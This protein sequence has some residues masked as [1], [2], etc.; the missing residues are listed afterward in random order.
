MSTD[1]PD[2]LNGPFLK[3]D[4]IFY[5][6]YQ[7]NVVNQCKNKNSLVVLPTGLGKTIVGILQIA[8]CL[9]KHKSLA[10]V[11][12]LAPTKPL[13]SQH[14]ASIEKFVDIDKEKIV[15]LTGKTP[16]EKRI[17]LFNKSKIIVSTPQV[18]K[19][20]L[21]RGRYD[22]KSVGLIIFDEA[23]R[24]KGNYAYNFISTE[25]INNCRDPLILGLTAS[26]GN[27]FERIQ[28]LCDNLYI[29]NI[30]FKT[31]DD[32]DVKDYIFDV[33]T[34]IERVDLPLNLLEISEIWNHLFRNFLKFFTEKNL[35]N[36]YKRYYSK[37]D[38]LKISHDLTFSLKNESCQELDE[39]LYFQSPKIIDIVKEKK[40]NI[41]SIFS[42]CSSCISILH[43]KDLFETQ[44]ISLFKSFI[45]KLKYKAEQ[46]ILSAKRII[47]SEHFKFINSTIEKL[48]QSNLSHPKINKLI[49]IIREE[50]EEFQNKK[51]IIFTQ[52]RQMAE[53]LKNKLN[54][55][56]FSE[57]TVEKFIGQTTKR[58]DCGF[59]QNKQIEI[60]QE[61]REDKI[62]ILIATSVAE[63]G[64]D[65]PNVDAVIFYEPVP[66]EIRLIQRRGRTGRFASGRCYILLTESTVDIPFHIVANKK[67]HNMNS[68]LNEPEQLELNKGI[69]RKKINFS[70]NNKDYSEWAFIKNFKER[71]EREKEL[72]ADRSVEDIITEIDNF[73]KS[74]DYKNL[75]NYGVSFYSDLIRIDK[76]K[77]RKNISKLKGKK[78]SKSSER[79]IYLNKNVKTLINIAKISR[80]GKVGFSEF[81]DLA[82]EEDICDRKF[83]AHFN[84][85]C[86]L[87][88]LKKS[89][90]YVQ[91]IKDFN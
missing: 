28:L 49:S 87:G 64:L 26:P 18:I 16:P 66:S 80:N 29:E 47:N 69:E 40:L 62:N 44:D 68:I 7:K 52:Y 9:K 57:I 12:I 41:Q 86:Y 50:L 83:F 5:R 79:K 60:L 23:H 82:R 1:I 63:E 71:R 53:L 10:K 54:Q 35:I 17:I 72:L 74:S 14:R 38:F 31:I 22:L 30:V 67:E 51:I 46:D 59:P 43:A 76:E 8:N 32:H 36:P 75:K 77:L 78:I 34:F 91:F 85:A 21:M 42:Y 84:Q 15:L 39:N 55:E 56:F 4:R 48:G 2:Y 70:D 45:E 81:Q 37:L 65:I 3:K 24:T 25:Y 90:D 20:D 11:I 61:F 27:D 73:A 88:Y 19:N 33:D 58:D 89:S 13:V 6:H